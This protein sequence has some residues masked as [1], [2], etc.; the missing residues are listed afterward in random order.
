[1]HATGPSPHPVTYP[2]VIYRID[3]G[4]V[5]HATVNSINADAK[6]TDDRCALKKV[7]YTGL[8][9]KV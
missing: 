3:I 9:K 1:M 6:D 4:V 2:S 8:F 5:V 7:R